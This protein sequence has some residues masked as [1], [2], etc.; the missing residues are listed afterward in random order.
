MGLTITNGNTQVENNVSENGEADQNGSNENGELKENPWKVTTIEV[1][2][3][4]IIEKKEKINLAEIVAKPAKY[5]APIPDEAPLKPIR[6]SKK[7]APD[8]KN[9]EFFPSLGST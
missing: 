8:L 3:V 9:E 6:L 7:Q 1:P 2:K 4:E 5:R